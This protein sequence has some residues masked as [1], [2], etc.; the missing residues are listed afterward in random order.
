MMGK[1]EGRM[2]KQVRHEYIWR[3]LLRV[4]LGLRAMAICINGRLLESTSLENNKCRPV[5]SLPNEG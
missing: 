1:S 2:E 4:V 3:A 5:L